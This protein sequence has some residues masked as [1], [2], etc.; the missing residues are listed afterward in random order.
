[1]KNFSKSILILIYFFSISS[2]GQSNENFVKQYK[3]RV[4]L[5]TVSSITAGSNVQSYK[6]FTYLDGLGS[7][8]QV[9]LAQ[10]SVNSKDII[11][12]QIRDSFGRFSKSFLPYVET[13][14]T[15]DGRFRPTSSAISTQASFYST[16][17]SDSSPFSEIGFEPSPLNR[18]HLS[19]SPGNSWKMGSGKETE[20]QRR[21]NTSD[22]SVKILSLNLSFLPLS[23]TR[24]YLEKNLSVEV[25]I[26]EDNKKVIEYKDLLGRL[27]LK[28]VQDSS[29]PSV[30][31]TG[32]LCTYYVYDYRGNLR[33]VIPPAAVHILET[34][35]WTLST[36][37]TLAAEQYYLYTYDGKGRITHKKI[38]GK[39]IEYFLYDSQD[40]LVGSQD[41]NLRTLNKWLITKYDALGRVI[42]TGL[43]TD[44]VNSFETLQ[45]SLNSGSNNASVS[46][47]TSV[48]GG[49]PT[50]VSEVLSMNYYDNYDF[51]TAFTY[52]LSGVV[53]NP[54]FDASNSSRVQSLQTG[55]RIKNLE[56]GQFNI[57]VFFYDSKGRLIQTLAQHQLGGTLRISNKYNFESQITNNFVESS[58]SPI[59]KVAR[60]F[61]YNVAGLISSISH[62]IN[63]AS[64]KII[65]NY[66]YND[67]G[68]LINKVFPEA[69]S[70][71]QSFV[72][73]IRGWLQQLNS[74]NNN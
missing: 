28:K 3:A 9:V 17:T 1:M 55:K 10:Q 38:P 72:Y 6:T 32:W 53:S 36:N 60:G 57:S 50:S 56:N 13:S 33:V 15:Q 58:V 46:S 54:G 29:N 73:N 12:P 61:T 16:L 66:Q 45:A 39:D 14:G 37:T 2:F 27:I 34:Q 67:I 21:S 62:S 43:F 41:G 71:N 23:S 4:P 64:S 48:T 44:S 7:T 30:A 63:G 70:A 31:H 24:T 52:S 51:L 5:T 18:T 68:Q 49:W 74:S 69:Q 8:K 22:E 59:T 42:L 26:D 40:R 65:A 35:G 20:I 25:Y 19:A 47:Q 11:T